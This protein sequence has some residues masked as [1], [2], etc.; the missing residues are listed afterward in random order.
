M[1]HVLVVDD[2][3]VSVLVIQRFLTKLGFLSSSSLNIFHILDDIQS[4][5][6]D[7]VTVDLRMPEVD[8]R[9]LIKMIREVDTTIPIIV[10]TAFVEEE[11]RI[12]CLQAGATYYLVKPISLKN[13]KNVLHQYIE[14]N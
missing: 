12:Q 1:K 10:I 4:K 5:L 11:K 6:V 13:L 8:G 7:I 2:D 3:Y 9:T 14:D